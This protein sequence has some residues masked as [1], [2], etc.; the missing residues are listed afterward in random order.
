VSEEASRRLESG[1]AAICAGE[2]NRQRHI[3]LT[4]GGAHRLQEAAPDRVLVWH[5][6]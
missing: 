3:V 1:Q 5:R 2:R 4:A 6:Q